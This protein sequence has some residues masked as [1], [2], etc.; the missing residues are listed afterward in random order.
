MTFTFSQDATEFS[1]AVDIVDDEF[2]EATES[3]LVLADIITDAPTVSLLPGQSTVTITDDDCKF[4]RHDSVIYIRILMPVSRI[5][6][7]DWIR[8][9]I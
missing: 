4:I 2:V 1:L 9:D 5:S 8:G 7:C 3:F 6:C